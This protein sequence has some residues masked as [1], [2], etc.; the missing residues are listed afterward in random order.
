VGSVRNVHG[1][2]EF[3]CVREDIRLI[4]LNIVPADCHVG[5][6]K[7]S[8]RTIKE[9]LRSCVHGLPFKHLPKLPIKHMVVNVVLC[10][11]QFPWKLGILETMSP[12]GIVSCTAM[13]D[14]TTMHL[15]EFGSYVQMSEDN[16]PSN[17]TP[18]ACSMGS[19]ALNPTGDA[20]GNY[21]Y[22]PLATGARI[23]RH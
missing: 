6:V 17:S 15:K 18:R 21:Y 10:L 3:A 7:R 12:A 14:F 23:S 19:I 9:R 16:T 13:P 2:A 5:K 1:D 11:N 22:M 8:V 4:E 20:Q